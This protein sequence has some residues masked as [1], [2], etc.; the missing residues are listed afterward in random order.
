MYELMDE[1]MMYQYRAYGRYRKKMK[2][3]SRFY[4]YTTFIL[5]RKRRMMLYTIHDKGYLE[6]VKSKLL[7]CRIGLMFMADR[8]G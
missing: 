1:L 8:I 5:P 3:E 2:K 6:S 4:I 7:G